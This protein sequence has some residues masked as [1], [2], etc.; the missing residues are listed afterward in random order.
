[1]M[2]NSMVSPGFT[3]KSSKEI[4]TSIVSLYAWF[5]FFN[6]WE[7]HKPPKVDL[8]RPKGIISFSLNENLISWVNWF[9]II[10]KMFSFLLIV[11]TGLKIFWDSFLK[12]KN[13]W[14]LKKCFVFV[15]FF[16]FISNLK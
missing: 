3:P 8:A 10:G 12:Y 15:I 7:I 11:L 9:S 1:M 13:I 5:T 6:N 16:L 4:A 14:F 2:Q